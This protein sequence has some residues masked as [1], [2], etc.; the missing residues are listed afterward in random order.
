MDIV[1]GSKVK[2]I[3]DS[4]CDEYKGLIGEVLVVEYVDLFKGDPGLDIIQCVGFGCGMWRS[5]FELV[6]E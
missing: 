3:D 2:V 6:T 1:K 5:R 4:G